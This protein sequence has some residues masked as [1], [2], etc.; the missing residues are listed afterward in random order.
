MD[1]D[2]LNNEQ[3]EQ[4]VTQETQDMTQDTQGTERE[5]SMQ[6]NSTQEASVQETLAQESSKQQESTQQSGSFSQSYQQQQYYQQPPYQQQAPYQ[7]DS[8]LEEPVSFANWMLT[9][10]VMLIPIVNIIML[11][12]WAFG[13]TKRSKSNYFK[14][15]LAWAIIW[16]V[17]A[18]LIAIGLF[19]CFMMGYGY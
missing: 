3:E 4:S 19:V 1:N 13:N 8:G 7:P 16:I 18:A 10:L 5:A 17:V 6:E 12:V 14:A 15:T 2:F 11:F 9:K